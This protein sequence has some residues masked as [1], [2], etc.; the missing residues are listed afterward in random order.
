M[1]VV[2]DTN[3][4]VSAVLG[5]ALAELLPA[6]RAGHFTLVVSDEI[7]GEYHRVL[8]RPKFG[9]SED[10]VDDIIG[11]VFRSAEFF[12]PSERLNIVREDPSDNKFIE[13][14]VAG[15]ADLIVSGDSHL[16]NLGLYADIPILPARDF[17]QKVQSG[18]E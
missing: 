8:S 17:L 3:V 16:L 7:V 5:G 6:W 10:V 1:R 2:L 18:R 9:L 11:L 15:G 4:F 14:A 13:A 12:T